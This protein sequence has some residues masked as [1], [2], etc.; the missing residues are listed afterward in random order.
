[1]ENPELSDKQTTF[2]QFAKNMALKPEDFADA[3]TPGNP[4]G[5][6][7]A[8]EIFARMVDVVPSV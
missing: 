8:S 7:N 4:K 5:N 2:V 3:V 6:L 1:M